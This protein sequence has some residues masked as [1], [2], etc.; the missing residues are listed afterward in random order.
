MDARLAIACAHCGTPV[1]GALDPLV[2]A[3]CCA[4]CRTAADVIKACGLGEYHRLR[5]GFGAVEPVAA[6]QRPVEDDAAYASSVIARKDGSSAI[7]WHVEGVRCAACVWLLERFACLDGGVRC[8]RLDLSAACLSI[9]FDPARTTPARMVAAARALGYRLRPYA[10]GAAPAERLRERRALLLRFAVSLASTLAAMHLGLNVTAGDLAGDMDGATRVFF[11]VASFA[12]ALP[13]LTWS[14]APFWR[15]AVA[16]IRARRWTLDAT[17]AAVL[18][19]AIA[20]G[21]LAALGG[22]AIYADAAAMFVCLLLGSRLILAAALDRAAR[23]GAVVDG[24]I[25]GAARRIGSDGAEQMVA[26]ASLALGQRVRVAGGEALPCDGIAENSGWIEAAVLT[27]EARA[28]AVAPGDAVL[29]GAR[30]RAELIVR[31]TAAGQAT[32][33]GQ[34]LARARLAAQR[35][36]VDSAADRLQAWFAPAVLALAIATAAAWSASGTQAAINQAMA[37]ILV[38]CPCAIGL[39]GPL[40][41]AV[42]ISG[43]ARRGLLLRDPDAFE[44]MRSAK[45]IVL[46][47]TGTLTA[48]AI[49]VSRWTWLGEGGAGERKVIEDAAYSAESR[50]RHPTAAAVAAW[51]GAHGAKSIALDDWREAAGSGISCRVGGRELRIG[52]GSFTG[53]DGDI[54][55]ALDGRPAVILSVDDPPLPDAAA[56]VARLR[57]MGLELSVCSGDSPQAVD[58]VA[59]QVGIAKV[60]AACSPEQKT[61]IVASLSADGGVIMVGDG[62]NDAPALSAADAGIGIRGG[63]EPCLECCGAFVARGGL[64]SAVDLIEASRRAHAAERLCLAVSLLYNIV[65][66]AAVISGVAGPLVCAAAMPLSSATV[67]LIAWRRAPFRS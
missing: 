20:A 47:K 66:I 57:A 13:A 42:A 6:T 62:V 50:S 64:S 30:S 4:G 32:R 46:D 67:V 37:M 34:L 1:P 56:L 16:S 59:E 18:A 40:V 10:A 15:G 17:I 51:L 8:A 49:T 33:I 39:A 29:G 35:E 65:G 60:H 24:V 2:A 3:Y 41:R 26:S 44:R 14:A 25:P 54:G 53:V 63:L 52:S 21:G 43:A 36:R 27:G 58:T 7:A 45:H 5:S 38:C 19:L 23:A 48:G 28:I 31:V 11:A 12:A 9:V 22:G 61:A 55:I